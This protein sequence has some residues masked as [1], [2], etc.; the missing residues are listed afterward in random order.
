MNIKKYICKTQKF[1]IFSIDKN[2][3][4]AEIKIDFISLFLKFRCNITPIVNY[5]FK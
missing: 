2:I 1:I 4:I 5:L 3:L